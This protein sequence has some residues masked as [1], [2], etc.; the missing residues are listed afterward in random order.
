MERFKRRFRKKTHFEK[1]LGRDW[2]S[3]SFDAH[4]KR[5]NDE[6]GGRTTKET[7]IRNYEKI[8]SNYELVWYSFT[9]LL[10]RTDMAVKNSMFAS[11]G[12][13]QAGQQS[14]GAGY[15]FFTKDPTGDIGDNNLQDKFAAL[16][17]QEQN[18][19]DYLQKLCTAFHCYFS[20]TIVNSK[21]WAG[22]RENCRRQEQGLLLFLG[23]R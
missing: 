3:K 6:W 13:A 16:S 7:S 23:W 8:I 19:C 12:I 5:Q 10:L 14:I 22:I 9:N 1:S 15:I 2:T 18:R 20:D 17:P 4:M 21:I 11:M